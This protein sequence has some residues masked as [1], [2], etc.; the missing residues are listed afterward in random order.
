MTACVTPEAILSDLQCRASHIDGLAKAIEEMM[1]GKNAD[2]MIVASL[3][4]AIVLLASDITDGF[5]RAELRQIE[6]AA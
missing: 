5:D 3:A 6:G 1:H 2:R 4:S